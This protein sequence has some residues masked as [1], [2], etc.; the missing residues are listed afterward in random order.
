MKLV[1]LSSIADIQLGK[2]LSPKARIGS[3]FSAYLRNQNV[4]TC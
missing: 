2:M 1:P 4:Q 3:Q